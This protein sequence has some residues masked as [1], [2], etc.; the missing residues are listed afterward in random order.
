MEEKTSSN[1]YE[2][3]DK[4]M[5][6]LKIIE[7]NLRELSSKDDVSLQEVMKLRDEANEHYM[8]CSNILKEIANRNSNTNGQ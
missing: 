1:N 8:F 7:K 6:E 2:E 4:R 5:E 3:F